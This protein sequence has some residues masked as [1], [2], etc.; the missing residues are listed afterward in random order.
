MSYVLG[1]ICPMRWL[2]GRCGSIKGAQGQ[3]HATRRTAVGS[4]FLPLI[5]VGCFALVCPSGLAHRGGE[6]RGGRGDEDHQRA[7]AG[8]PVAKAPQLG[9]AAVRLGAARGCPVPPPSLRS[10]LACKAASACRRMRCPLLRGSFLAAQ[11]CQRF[12]RVTVRPLSGL[13]A[14]F[15]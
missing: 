3:V 1:S 15:L 4:P 7:Q 10:C 5:R 13:T 9:T 6:V 11:F 2:P 12:C 8:R 14:H